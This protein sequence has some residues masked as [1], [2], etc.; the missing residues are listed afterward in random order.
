MYYYFLIMNCFSYYCDLM[1]IY[2]IY[3]LFQW[4]KQTKWLCCKETGCNPPNICVDLWRIWPGEWWRV[5][6]SAWICITRNSAHKRNKIQS[7]LSFLSVVEKCEETVW[8]VS[9]LLR[10]TTACC[11]LYYYISIPPMR[12]I[13]N[14]ITCFK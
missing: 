4:S 6:W 10:L 5:Y 12:K 9:R 14:F 13:F 2:N 7:Y 3:T 1:M 8:T 11:H